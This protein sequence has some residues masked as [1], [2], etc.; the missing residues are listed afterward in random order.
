MFWLRGEVA[1]YVRRWRGR[2]GLR[3][4]KQQVR[5]SKLDLRVEGHAATM[6]RFASML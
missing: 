4:G 1:V 3:R 5:V 6:C 2:N